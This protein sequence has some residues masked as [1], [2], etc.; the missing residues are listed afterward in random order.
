MIPGAFDYYAPRSLDD[1][2]KYLSAHKEDVKIL[3]GGQ[4]LLPL[5]TRSGRPHTPPTR[6][7]KRVA[8]RRWHNTPTNAVRF[9]K[10]VGRSLR[11][12]TAAA[13]ES[14]CDP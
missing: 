11:L 6:R 13:P 4:S 2:V 9:F 1:A 8:D 10:Q 14:C 12:G 5:M 7:Q 3:S